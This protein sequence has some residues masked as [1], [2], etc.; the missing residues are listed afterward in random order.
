MGPGPVGLGDPTIGPITIRAP[1]STKV[2]N[3]VTVAMSA[4]G[5]SLIASFNKGDI[6]N[7]VPVGDA[8]PL[9]VSANFLDSSGVQQKLQGTAN[10]RV[11]K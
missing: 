4:D 11:L 1:L 6:D 2:F 8:V 5:K 7:N 3:P 9:I 10:L